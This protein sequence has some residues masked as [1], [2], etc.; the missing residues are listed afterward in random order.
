M[1]L[2]HDNMRKLEPFWEQRFAILGDTG[3][4]LPLVGK[5]DDGAANAANG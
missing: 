4:I 5:G 3:V 1:S 2:W